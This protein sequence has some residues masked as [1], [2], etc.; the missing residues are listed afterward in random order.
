M[1]VRNALSSLSTRETIAGRL[2]TVASS[3]MIW[4]NC[5]SM[6]AIAVLPEEDHAKF[7]EVDLECRS[8]QDEFMTKLRLTDPLLFKLYLKLEESVN[9]R[10]VIRANAMYLKGTLDEHIDLRMAG[11]R[12]PE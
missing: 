7:L 12:A 8:L 4:S 1:G 3:M 6:V 10:A 9:E 2:R 5:P 11:W